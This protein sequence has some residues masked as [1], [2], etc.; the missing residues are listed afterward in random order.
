MNVEEVMTTHVVTVEP[1]DTVL[2]AA[3][4]MLQHRISGLPVV[5]PGGA[6]VGIVTEGDFLRRAEIGT[7]RKR[8]R[9]LE[10]LLSPGKRAEEYVHSHGR[11]VSE[12]M[13]PDPRTVTEDAALDDVVKV[14]EAQ[15]IKR[16][17]VLRDGKLVGIVTRA[18][19]LRAFASLAQEVG[20]PARDDETIR[21]WLIADL[22][23]RKWAPVPLLNIMVRNGIVE[24]WGTITDER[25]RQAIV[26][27]AENIPGVKG[28]RDHLAW[29]D[30]MSGH[31][32]ARARR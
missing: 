6:L 24:L 3:R 28:V 15:R 30:P 26:V 16:L 14:M 5:D 11:K 32:P 4:L 17:P 7:Q 23:A 31:V 9:W 2:H 29:I 25:Q 22:E 8:P 12:V 21:K 20:P 19:L 13:T 18:N 27:A 10:Y 1:G